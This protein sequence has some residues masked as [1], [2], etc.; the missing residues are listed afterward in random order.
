MARGWW[1]GWGGWRKRRAPAG[2]WASA[3]MRGT[4]HSLTDDVR[5]A[6]QSDQAGRVT[7]T[8]GHGM[9]PGATHEH[10]KVGC[11]AWT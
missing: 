6:T 10:G 4:T 2:P 3:P 1:E 9:S 8:L 7:S 5:H 11:E